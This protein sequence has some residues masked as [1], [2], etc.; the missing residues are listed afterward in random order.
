MPKTLKQKSENKTDLQPTEI[1]IQRINLKLQEL[2]KRYSTL[3]KLCAQQK[4]TIE[5]LTKKSNAAEHQVKMLQEQQLLLKSASGNMEASDKKALEQT[6][7]RYL[8]EIDKCI[9]L[10]G[11]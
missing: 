11:E 6:I 7:N 5:A 8:R 2:V 4:E 1:H 3:Q 9:A 10:L